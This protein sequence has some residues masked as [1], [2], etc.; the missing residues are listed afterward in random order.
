MT[1]R[2]RQVHAGICARRH[3]TDEPMGNPS[4]DDDMPGTTDPGEERGERVPL[5]APLALVTQLNAADEALLRLYY[6]R[7][8][9]KASMLDQVIELARMPERVTFK[10]ASQVFKFIDSLPGGLVCL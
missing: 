7:R 2:G 5:A 4:P 6:H 10:A 1:L 8:D 3:L 9:I